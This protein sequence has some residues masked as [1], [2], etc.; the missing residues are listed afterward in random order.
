[1]PVGLRH[2]KARD[3]QDGTVAAMDANTTTSP[4]SD[5][6]LRQLD[7]PGP[8]Y[9]SYPTA[10]RFHEAFG[11]EHYLQALRQRAEGAVVGASAPLSAYVHIPFCESV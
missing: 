7:V 3:A 5:A 9:T 6:M 2:I 1:V 11:A 8:R 4:L 10:D